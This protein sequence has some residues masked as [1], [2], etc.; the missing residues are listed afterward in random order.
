MPLHALHSA[1]TFHTSAHARN[2]AF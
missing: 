2:W 1:L